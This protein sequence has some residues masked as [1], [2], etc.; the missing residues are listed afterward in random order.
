VLSDEVGNSEV[1]SGPHARFYSAGDVDGL[2]AAVRSLLAATEGE[3]LGLRRA[4]RENAEQEFAARAVVPKLV[5]IVG[6]L[7]A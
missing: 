5:E 7:N 2:E 4:A 3:E 6:S 1:V